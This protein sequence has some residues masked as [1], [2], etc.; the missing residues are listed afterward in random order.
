MNASIL[1]AKQQSIGEGLRRLVAM[2]DLVPP[3]ALDWKNEE[4]ENKQTPETKAP[5]QNANPS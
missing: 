3:W 4:G 5:E 2:Q 1:E